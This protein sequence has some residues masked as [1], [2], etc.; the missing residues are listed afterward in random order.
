[1]V[2]LS[3]LTQSNEA[4][5][6]YEKLQSHPNAQ[7]N[8]KARQFVFSF[9]AMEMM[10]VTTSSPFYLKNT[11]YQN[12]F[13][14]FVENKSNYPLKEAEIEEGSLSQVLPY[15]IFL[16]SPIFAIL[17]IAIQKRI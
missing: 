12:F 14:A 10:K 16:V 1:M 3:R 17:L 5:L 2:Y 4:R 9:Q 8:K 11:G 15:I 13:E 6:M 7:V